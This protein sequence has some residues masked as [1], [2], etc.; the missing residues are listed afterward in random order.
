[1]DIYTWFAQLLISE[2]DKDP[3]SKISKFYHATQTFNMRDLVKTPI[4]TFPYGSTQHNIQKHVHTFF[5]DILGR[6]D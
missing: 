3:K 2:I 4:M 6:F 1:M 5:K